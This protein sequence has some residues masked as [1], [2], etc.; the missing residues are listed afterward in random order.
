MEEEVSCQAAAGG[1]LH[2]GGLV[3]KGRE[4][5]AVVRRGVAQQIQPG[6]LEEGA[7]GHPQASQRV[8]F[9]LLVQQHRQGHRAAPTG[10]VP[11]DEH[12]RAH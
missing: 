9:P 3:R 2:R 10:R 1:I 4:V 11:R 5:V 12:R 6:A 7:G 8:V